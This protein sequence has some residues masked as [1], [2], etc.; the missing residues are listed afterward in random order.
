MSTNN[1]LAR[2]SI[3]FLLWGLTALWFL[4]VTPEVSAKTYDFDEGLEA[5]TTGLISENRRILKNKK[6]AVFGIIESKSGKK[7]EVS[8]HIEDGIVDALVNHGCRVIERRRIQD[9]IQKEI[10]KSTDLWFDQ[11]RVAQFGKLVGADFV[12]TG[13]YVLWGQGM[14]KISVRAINVSDGEIVA[15]DK[16][17][18]LTDRIADLL[19]P[20]KDE[21]HLKVVK[22]SHEK[23]V[24]VKR[25]DELSHESG[26]LGK[27]KALIIGINDYEGPKIPD[28]ETAT[29]DATAV[30]KVLREKYGFEVKLLLDREATKEAIYR[31]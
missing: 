17:K 4:S 10:K 26:K 30:A 8:S 18:I 24:K 14:L 21:K 20:E 1:R 9:V 3:N 25:I 27:Y 7:W 28:L 16:V 11:A 19:K 13:S 22:D 12:V 6:I 15:A 5:V 2:V 29:N 23:A 31:E